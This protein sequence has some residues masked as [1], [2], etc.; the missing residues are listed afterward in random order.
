MTYVPI[1]KLLCVMV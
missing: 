1:Q